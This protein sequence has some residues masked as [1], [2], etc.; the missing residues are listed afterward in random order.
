MF[1]LFQRTLAKNYKGPSENLR[2]QSVYL[3]MPWDGVWVPLDLPCCLEALLHPALRAARAAAESSRSALPFLP[4]SAVA[5][6]KKE[7]PGTSKPHFLSKRWMSQCHQ[8]F[9]PEFYLSLI[10]LTIPSW[11]LLPKKDCVVSASIFSLAHLVRLGQAGSKKG[12]QPRMPLLPNG[13]GQESY[14]CGRP[15]VFERFVACKHMEKI[16][17]PWA[18]G[19]VLELYTKHVFGWI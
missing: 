12:P 11:F 15:V 3:V 10:I 9:S 18:N 2:W 6:A 1:K 4:R 5:K 7:H 14:R 19:T 8:A 13:W 16:R 17:A